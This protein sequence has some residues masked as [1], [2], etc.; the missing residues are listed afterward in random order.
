MSLPSVLPCGL[1]LC[2]A[3]MAELGKA[4]DAAA[5]WA[6]EN[7]RPVGILVIGD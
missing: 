5:K 2:A 4:L 7:K 1:N 6:K 3:Q